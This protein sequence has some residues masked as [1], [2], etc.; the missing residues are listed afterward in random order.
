MKPRVVCL[1]PHLPFL[2]TAPVKH[3]DCNAGLANVCNPTLSRRWDLSKQTTQPA[4]ERAADRRGG[5]SNI[6]NPM[7]IA[8]RGEGE[9]AELGLIVDG[10]TSTL[11]SRSNFSEP[12]GQ[13][14][15]LMESCGEERRPRTPG[16][17]R[18]LTLLVR[19]Q[20]QRLLDRRQ[21]A[22]G[23]PPCPVANSSSQRT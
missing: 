17:D 9:L 2:R 11:C 7:S 6:L 14:I 23:H 4:S 5:R 10:R 12:D 15:D 13:R 3:D 19:A 16:N 20:Q 22:A 21:R 1:P 8:E 18:S